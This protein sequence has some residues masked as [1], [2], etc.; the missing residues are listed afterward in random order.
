MI[1]KQDVFRDWFRT[2]IL[3]DYTAGPIDTIW[4]WPFSPDAPIYR[5]GYPRLVISSKQKPTY[6]SNL[7]KSLSPHVNFK[8]D[9]D[10]S[11]PLA[12]LPHVIL[13]GE[14]LLAGQNRMRWTEV[15]MGSGP[16]SLSLSHH[17]SNRIS[18]NMHSRDITSRFVADYPHTQ[19]K[20]TQRK[21]PTL[22]CS[23]F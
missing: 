22:F 4:V 13:P 15:N 23:I 10:Y 21:V 7:N 9:F 3:T 2:A 11:A 16:I 17:R 1:K 8:F 6:A 14:S 5:D 19:H 12:G 18:P 20:L